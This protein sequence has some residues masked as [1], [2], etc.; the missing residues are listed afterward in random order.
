MVNTSKPLAIFYENKI[1]TINHIMINRGYLYYFISNTNISYGTVVI[2]VVTTNG[3][4]FV[5]FIEDDNGDCIQVMIQIGKNGSQVRAWTEAMQELVNMILA[6]KKSIESVANVLENITTDRITI[7]LKTDED[8]RE[9]KSGP[10]GLV[11]AVDQYI[12]SKN[13]D[14]LAPFAMP[15]VESS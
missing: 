8:R 6:D 4:M 1:A 9:I 12:K 3:T 2:E 13:R 10:D 15:W 11:Y 14:S 7:S 5:A